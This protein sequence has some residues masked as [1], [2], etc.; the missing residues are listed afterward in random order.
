M[1]FMLA[2]VVT[3]LSKGQKAYQQVVV[4]E[5]AYWSL[6]Q[7]IDA[8]NEQKEPVGGTRSVQLTQQVALMRSGI[9]TTVRARYSTAFRWWCRR[10]DSRSSSVPPVPA[11]PPCWTLSSG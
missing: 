6:V 9:P 3:Y 4:R 11:R 7:A 10:A 5:S 2:R 1:L 8:A